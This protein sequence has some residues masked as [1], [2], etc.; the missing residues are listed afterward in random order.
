MKLDFPWSGSD[1]TRDGFQRL[2][3]GPVD[4][5]AGINEGRR[6]LLFVTNSE[7]PKL[8]NFA[9]ITFRRA[10][11][12]D[13][14]WSTILRLERPELRSLFAQVADDLA[15]VT[16]VHDSENA[17][18][19]AFVD[20]VRYW[21]ELFTTVGTGV[22][23]EES[24]KG[25]VGELLFLDLHALPRLPVSD[26][27]VAWVGPLR[28]PQDFIFKDVSIEVKATGVDA[29]VVEISS[30]EQLD[31]AGRSLRLGV[32]EVVVGSTAQPDSMSVAELVAR[33]RASCG[34]QEA[35]VSFE[36]RL[37]LAGYAPLPDYEQIRFSN[38]AFRFFD[39]RT[40]FPRLTRDSV[41][42]AIAGCAYSLRL[43]G[44]GS[45]AIDDWQHGA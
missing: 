41:S 19:R 33:V 43:T 21:R 26:A 42:P 13:G 7:P 36:Q 1:D 34:T 31:V 25:L 37:Q 38:S 8:P 28:R 9:A 14:R 2:S 29:E 30:L 44:I 23:G 16:L 20:R 11:R 40:D 45:Y 12:D 17:A 24:L 27:I 35:R 5:W 10:R 3:P 22:L 32:V 39:I 15:R 4:L 6:A 18:Y